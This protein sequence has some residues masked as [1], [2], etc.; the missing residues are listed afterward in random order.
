MKNLTLNVTSNLSLCQSPPL[1]QLFQTVPSTVNSQIGRCLV[2]NRQHFLLLAHW[3]NHMIKLYPLHF[4]TL[5]V[6][7]PNITGEPTTA[8][9]TV[10]LLEQRP[11]CNI[12]SEL[13]KCELRI[14]SHHLD[15]NQSESNKI[16]LCSTKDI[17]VIYQPIPI[18]LH[19]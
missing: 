6:V 15:T 14:I 1:L 8:V 19:Y 4:K 18:S 16:Q 3:I 9:I 12:V 5:L 7:Y 13:C 10:T 2:D 11:Y 17:C